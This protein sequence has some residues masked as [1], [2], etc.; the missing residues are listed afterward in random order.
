MVHAEVH[1]QFVAKLVQAVKDELKFG[2]ILNGA[3]M[4]PMINQMG[5][6]KVKRHLEDALE[7]GAKLEIGGDSL[8]GLYLQPTVVSNVSWDSL[9]FKEETFGPRLPSYNNVCKVCFSCGHRKVRKRRN[10]NRLPQHVK[11][12]SSWLFLQPRCRSGVESRR[13]A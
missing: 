9:C 6:E 3:T 10:G 7:K 4:G 13:C 12:R 11:S 1:D 8:G 5:V 2:D